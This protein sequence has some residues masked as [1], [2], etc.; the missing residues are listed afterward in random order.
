MVMDGAVVRHGKGKNVD[1]QEL[2]IGEWHYDVMHGEGVMSFGSNATYRGS[3]VENK[4]N[5]F[6]TYTWPDGAV[7]EGYWRDNK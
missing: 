1:D 5:G 3:F 2:F 6:G 7:Y 4:F